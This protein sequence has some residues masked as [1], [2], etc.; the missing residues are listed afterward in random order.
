MGWQTITFEQVQAFCSVLG[1]KTRFEIVRLVSK[2]PH[3]VTEICEALDSKQTKISNDLKCLRD[4]GYVHVEKSGNSRIY[5]LD[6]KIA[7]V[8]ASVA[9]QLRSV[10]SIC[11]GCKVCH[12]SPV[13][14]KV[15]SA[16]Y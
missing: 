7:P 3:T 4:C 14:R 8:L 5:S 9:S 12:S 1:N 6:E 13:A 2:R 10:E 16:D 15:G 11:A